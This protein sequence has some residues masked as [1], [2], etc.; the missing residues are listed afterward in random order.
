MGAEDDTD[1]GVRLLAHVRDAFEITARPPDGRITT[2]DL[3]GVL[4]AR[5]D[6]SPWAGWWAKDVESNTRKPA[7][8]L[9]Q[10]CGPT[11]STPKT[12]GG[13]R[14]REGLRAGRFRGRLGSLCAGVATLAPS[15]ATPRSLRRYTAGQSHFPKSNRTYRKW[16]LTRTVAT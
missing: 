12:F 9:A 5:G 3:L 16:P 1:Y 8:R 4:V 7:M 6:D 2:A 15:V 11:A 14:R 10:C 13:N